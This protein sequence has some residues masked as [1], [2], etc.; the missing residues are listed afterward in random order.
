MEGRNSLNYDEQCGRILSKVSAEKKRKDI[1]GPGQNRIEGPVP[2]AFCRHN[3][4][5]MDYLQIHLFRNVKWLTHVKI[6]FKI[7][8]ESVVSELILQHA[9]N[10]FIVGCNYNNFKYLNERGYKGIRMGREAILNLHYN[11]FRKK[12][13][14]ELIRRGKKSGV[15]SE[16][17]WSKE[18]AEAL[19]EFRKYTRHGSEPQLQ[20]LF[21]TYFEESNRLFVIKKPDGLWLGAML[22]SYKSDKYVQTE[23][24]LTRQKEPNGTME[25][26]IFEIFKTLKSEG[27]DYW[28]LGAVP[29]IIRDSTFLS[30]EYVINVTGRF[31]KFAYNYKGLFNFKNKF[32]PVWADY[33]ICIRPHFSLGAM[34]GILYQSNLLKLGIHKLIH[35][36]RK[37]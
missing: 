26:L 17:P 21:S 5:E 35:L 23:A 11:H 18:S 19:Q 2:S 9:K 14:K 8:F 20:Y 1:P 30:K 3:K 15:V 13:L 37:T 32:N 16:I 28:T 6:P 31:M 24:M 12:S 36:G 27:Y 22:L 33:Y 25:A 34:A 7:D 10:Y 29:F 4:E